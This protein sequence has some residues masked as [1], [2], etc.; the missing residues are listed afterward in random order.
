MFF[1]FSS[2]RRHTRS[3]RDWSS[4]VCS[5]DLELRDAQAIENL[6]GGGD[7]EEVG[8]QERPFF[9][10]EAQELKLLGHALPDLR[11]GHPLGGA[12]VSPQEPEDRVVRNGAAI[13]DAGCVKLEDSEALEGL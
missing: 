12:E 13:G 5:S 9:P 6:L 4:D 10:L 3:D 8:E 2:R 1:F 11:A 7:A